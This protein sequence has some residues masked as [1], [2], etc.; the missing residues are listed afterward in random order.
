MRVCKQENVEALK[1]AL[2]ICETSEY[3]TQA[4]TVM[5]SVGQRLGYSTR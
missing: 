2:F 3:L 1:P 4:T 5:H